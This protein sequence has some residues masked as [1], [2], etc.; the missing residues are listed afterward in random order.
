MGGSGG[1]KGTSGAG[2]GQPEYGVVA[3]KAHAGAHRGVKVAKIDRVPTVGPARGNV[4]PPVH[5][6]LTSRSCGTR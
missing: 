1:V 3:R 5:T 6:S 2:S 4:R